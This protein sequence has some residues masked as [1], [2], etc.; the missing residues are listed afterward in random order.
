MAAACALPDVDLISLDLSAR[1]PFHFRHKMFSTAVQRG[2]KFEICY[3]AATRFSGTD[4]GVSGTGPTGGNKDGGSLDAMIPAL[5]A[6][7]ARRNLIAN[8]TS[9]IRALRGRSVVISG[10]ARRALACRGPSDVVN[11]AC[12]WGLKQ[13]KGVEAIGK[14]ARA[15]V[16]QAELRRRGWRGVV[17]VVSGGAEG[18][19]KGRPEGEKQRHQLE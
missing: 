19:S 14:Q 2:I 7:T 5:D 10:E 6:A 9:L 17:D 8:A 12:V 1:Y 13:E 3:G 15:V 4:S 16:V 11:L 18:K